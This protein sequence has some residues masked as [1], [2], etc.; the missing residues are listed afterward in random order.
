MIDSTQA[1]AAASTGGMPSERTAAKQ[2]VKSFANVLAKSSAD[3]ESATKTTT[4]TT[5]KVEPRPDGEQTKRVTGHPYSKI[6]NGEDRG[7]F[8]N[9]V[10][11]NPRMGKAF[12]LVERD[13]HVFH[14][15]GTGR[16]RVIIGLPQKSAAD[17]SE[18]TTTKS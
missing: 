18:T 12:K 9:Q 16:D 2:S 7:L 3:T 4:T 8:V 10:T 15:Y 6:L 11:G 17:T 5:A 13:D 14:I 1:V